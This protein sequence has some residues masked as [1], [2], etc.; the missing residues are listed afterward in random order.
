MI[1]TFFGS[2]TE[3]GLHVS[4]GEEKS[5]IQTYFDSQ[6]HSSHN[7][8][9]VVEKSVPT[10]FRDFFRLFRDFARI[11]DKSKHLGLRLYPLHPRLLHHCRN[12]PRDQ[13]SRPHHCYM[14]LYRHLTNSLKISMQYS[15]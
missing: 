7:E 5:Q 8:N 10:F 1:K 11:F 2:H 9:K 4:Y 13:V 6:S 3:K 12:W 14:V 15:C